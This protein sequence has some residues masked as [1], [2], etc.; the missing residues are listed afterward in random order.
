MYRQFTRVGAEKVPDDKTVGRLA[1]ALG[2]EIIES[3]HERLVAIAQEKKI[4]EQQITINAQ[5]EKMSKLELQIIKI[6]ELEQKLELL[7]NKN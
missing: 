6:Q 4:E 1:R 2:P 3:I 5:N 7:I